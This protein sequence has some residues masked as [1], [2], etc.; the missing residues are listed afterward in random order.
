MTH[1]RLLSAIVLATLSAGTLQLQAD[2]IIL[3]TGESIPGTIRQIN[4]DTIDVETPFAGLIHVK[5]SAIKTLRSE[6]PVTIVQPQAQP[7]QAYVGPVSEGSG[8]RESADPLPPI[9]VASTEAPI[10]APGK[11]YDVNLEPYYLPLGPHWKNQFSLGVVNTTGNTESTSFAS[12][13]ALN[14]KLEPSELNLKIGGVYDVNN[15]QQTAGQFYF[16]AIYRRTMSEWDKSDR[17][18]IFAENHELYDG[19][20]EISYRITNAVGAGYYVF[21]DEKFTLDLRAGPAYVCE[22]FFSGDTESNFSGL[23]GLRA[24][25]VLN[26]RVSLSE[27]ALYTV[28]A[29][30]V[31]QYQITSET[32]LNVKL[33]EVARGAGMKLAF[34]DDYTSTVPAGRKNN[35]TRLTLSFTLDF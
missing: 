27:D 8:W 7:R 20:K 32:A 25:Y 24:V 35:D 34:R 2:T 5:R 16:D 30:D 12:E 15:G 11:V 33:P 18:Y 10:P 9:A 13:L 17:W 6:A 1:Y 31:G 29:C 3:T 21:K 23:V 4:A 26:D 19:I 22:K 14:Y 28:A